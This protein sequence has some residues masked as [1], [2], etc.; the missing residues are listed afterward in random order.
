MSGAQS[1]PLSNDITP[2]LAFI[3]SF[4]CFCSINPMKS[5][6]GRNLKQACV[7]ASL[8]AANTAA[9]TGIRPEVG[10]YMPEDERM[11]PQPLMLKDIAG[12]ETNA[13]IRNFGHMINR[14]RRLKTPAT[15]LVKEEVESYSKGELRIPD[16]VVLK[17]PCKPPTQDNLLGVVEVKFRGDRWGRG[18]K[19]A[20]E[21]IAGS[22]NGLHELNEDTCKCKGTEQQLLPEDNLQPAKGMYEQEEEHGFGE[23][24]L[25]GL[26]VAVIGVAMAALVLDDATGI[27]TADD[28]LLA[29]LGARAALQS[30]RLASGTSTVV[31]S[32][33]QAA[34]LVAERMHL[35]RPS[36]ERIGAAF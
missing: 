17:D 21:A 34:H 15:A 24:L 3:C 16:A 29:P 2:K 18:Q 35:L 36:L 22:P 19:D 27:G 30:A 26:E 13:P 8:D 20:Y 4:V 14:V 25:L 32:S 7:D 23:A 10:Y 12:Q 31:R 9:D 33:S 28:V 6:T 5:K 11:S 1:C